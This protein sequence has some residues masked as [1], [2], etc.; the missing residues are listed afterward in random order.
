MA[1]LE[2]LWSSP[3]AVRLTN[4]GSGGGRWGAL[5]GVESCGFITI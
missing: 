1:Y 4:A 2:D 5:I 3:Y